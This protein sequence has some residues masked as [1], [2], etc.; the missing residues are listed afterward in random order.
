MRALIAVSVCLMLAMTSATQRGGPH[1]AH[2]R[3]L[4]HATVHLSLDHTL[5]VPSTEADKTV[6][7]CTAT[8]GSDAITV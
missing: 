2:A 6:F 8:P 3:A 4:Y 1:G 5:T 7:C